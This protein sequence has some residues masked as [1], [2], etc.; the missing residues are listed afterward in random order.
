MTYKKLLL[1][2]SLCLACGALFFF[3]HHEWLIIKFIPR[4]TNLFSGNVKN[5][6]QID[7]CYWKDEKEGRLKTS[8]VWSYSAEEN[9]SL[10]ID[11][12]LTL[13]ADEKIL[14][15]RIA[16]ESVALSQNGHVIISCDKKFFPKDFS[17]Y[18]KWH[19]LQS[20]FHTIHRMGLNISLVTI[21]VKN[22]PMKDDHLDFSRPIS[23]N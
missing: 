14:L 22:S 5:K 2:S 11:G 20:L 9:L 10:V 6:K 4:G 1:L 7:L 3:L 15:H 21:L 23:L 19:I 17:L 16:L 18:K 13:M 8:V 12:W